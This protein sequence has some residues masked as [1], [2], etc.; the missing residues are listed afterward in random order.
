MG[1][2][3]IGFAKHRYLF[4]YRINGNQVIVEGMYHELQATV[5]KGL[6]AV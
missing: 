5:D 6:Q 1:L 4:V 3:R 2:H